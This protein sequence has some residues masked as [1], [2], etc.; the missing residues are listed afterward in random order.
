MHLLILFEKHVPPKMF[1]KQSDK[2]YEHMKKIIRSK[3]LSDNQT[4]VI[5]CNKARSALDLASTVMDM[6]SLLG[7]G[8][9][10]ISQHTTGQ[11]VR[12][13]ANAAEAACLK[14][15]EK[16]TVLSFLGALGCLGAIAHILVEDIRAKLKDG[17]W[18]NKII[19]QLD[20]DYH[21]FCKKMEVL[22]M[23][24][25][26]AEQNDAQKIMDDILW[27]GVH[28]AE[29]YVSKLIKDAEQC[30][31]V[32][33]A[34]C[35][36]IHESSASCCVKPYAEKENACRSILLCQGTK[37]IKSACRITFHWFLVFSYCNGGRIM[38]MIFSTVGK[39]HRGW[40]R[41]LGRER[42]GDAATGRENGGV[43]AVRRGEE[44]RPVQRGGGNTV[45]VNSTSALSSCR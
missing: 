9:T 11:M 28:H 32:C 30:Q 5:L 24:I 8:T 12:L 19:F 44:T 37:R 42:T 4:A 40:R 13:Y 26:L 14:G 34:A 6:T 20:T 23:E 43:A 27:N 36:A 18:K 2:I 17:P 38:S 7:L 1:R 25:D 16:D 45:A 3:N 31:L 39:K 41:G 15:V 22:K 35:K 10:E 21:E 29:S 33:I